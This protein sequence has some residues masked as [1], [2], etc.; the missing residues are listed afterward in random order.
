MNIIHPTLGAGRKSSGYGWRVLNGQRE[1]H[2]GVD[3]A[4]PSGTPVFAVLPGKVVYQGNRD[5]N[6]YGQQIVIQHGDKLFSQYGHLSKIEVTTGQLVKAGQRIGQIG[7]TGRSFGA[8]LH[9]EVR[10][11]N[12][13]PY[14]RL[15]AEDF[16]A[17]KI[18]LKP[19]IGGSKLPQLVIGLLVAGGLWAL[20]ELA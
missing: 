8:H 13:V 20:T 10:S 9:F 5:P 1:F 2:P 6:G 18:D 4:A 14:T 16:L 11:N 19:L 12:G 15:N 7:S 3:F 17:G